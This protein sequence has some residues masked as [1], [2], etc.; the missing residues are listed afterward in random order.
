MSGDLLENLERAALIADIGG[1]ASMSSTPRALFWWSIPSKR[2]SGSRPI[3][4]SNVVRRP[5]RS[6]SLRRCRGC[7]GANGGFMLP[8]Q[9]RE[10]GEMDM[11]RA[12]FDQI[13]NLEH[14]LVRLA[15][16]ST[17]A[18]DDEIAPLFSNKGRPGLPSH[19]AVG[20]L[21]VTHI[22]TLFDDQACERW[23]YT[24]PREMCIR[25]WTA[26]ATSSG[27]SRERK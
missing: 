24:E 20:L 22:D 2:R 23:V 6:P 12:R 7:V 16:R 21:P 10:T 26:F 8:G 5:A 11:L 3:L 13:I 15:R 14:E 1:G 25:S 4:Q 17:G 19:F 9:Q 27:R 18:G